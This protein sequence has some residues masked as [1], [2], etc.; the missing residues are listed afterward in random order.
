MALYQ[1][2][3][4]TDLQT[5]NLDGALRQIK[6]NTDNIADEVTARTAAVNSLD[7][8]ITALE[9]LQATHVLF[10]GDSY[11]VTSVVGTSTW[12]TV[13]ADCMGKTVGTDAFIASQGSVG[14]LNLITDTNNFR[15]LMENAS[16]PNPYSVGAIIVCG[17]ANDTNG[18]ESA[19]TSAI[20]EFM[21]SAKTHYPNAKV[22]VG[23]I[24]NFAAGFRDQRLTV[25]N[26]Y[27][28]C[29]SY[30]AVY[31]NGVEFVNHVY[32]Q[33]IDEVHPSAA[34]CLELGRAIAQAYQSGSVNINR[35]SQN[36]ITLTPSGVATELRN[37]NVD[38]AQ[39]NGMIKYTFYSTSYYTDQLTVVTNPMTVGFIGQYEI[40]TLSGANLAIPRTLPITGTNCR[41]EVAD[42]Q[43]GAAGSGTAYV[44]LGKDKLYLSFY[45]MASSGSHAPTFTNV[46]R[47]YLSNF[48]IIVPAC[49]S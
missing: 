22:Y 5:L 7:A 14:F 47:F 35:Y 11:A 10:V 26:A 25:E 24:G 4:Y 3:P 12:A 2:Y 32:N 45:G 1:N 16:V 43:V 37:F 27:K 44:S 48:S 20:S 31:L 49:I 46:V 13:A 19:I 30:G 15:T 9:P 41:C 18:T 6:T 23:M 42:N 36:G 8:R 29:V 34:M 38:C 21:Q 39:E 28:K 17:G 33:F 40:A